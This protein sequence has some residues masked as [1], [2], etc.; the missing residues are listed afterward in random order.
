MR[1][2]WMAGTRM[3]E[4]LSCASCTISSAR[5]VSTAAISCSS[6]YSFRPI[7]WVAMDLTLTT[8]VAPV[9]RTRSMT[10]WFASCASVAQCT[11]PPR[12]VT[13]ASS[14]SR[15]S[16][17]RAITSVLIA[18]PASR[19]ASQSGISS[20]TRARLARMV[21]VAWARFRRSWAFASSLRAAFGKGCSPRIGEVSGSAV[22][23]RCGRPRNVA[24]LMP[25]S[26]WWTPGCWPDVLC[27]YGFGCGTGR[28]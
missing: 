5:S 12:A 13:L 6:R 22:L 7:S 19:R 9:D 4:G 10:I 25:G 28:R 8:S 16:G 24:G 3:W 23:F 26:P 2:R 15:S 1:L 21:E 17:R 18:D 11:T 27:G 14:C 20:T